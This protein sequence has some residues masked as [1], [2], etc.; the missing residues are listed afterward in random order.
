MCLI[1]YFY[2]DRVRKK[3]DHFQVKVTI[4][5]KPNLR[6][7]IGTSP[8]I[9]VYLENCMCVVFIYLLSTMFNNNIL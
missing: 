5:K 3:N 1:I 4:T 9:I 2:A 8:F 7:A 6:M